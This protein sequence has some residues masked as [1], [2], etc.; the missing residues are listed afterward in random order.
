MA[1]S[2]DGYDDVFSPPSSTLTTATTTNPRTRKMSST[3]SNTNTDLVSHTSSAGDMRLYLQNLLDRKEKQLQQAGALGQRVLAQ[4]VELEERVRELQELDADK[5]LGE[6]DEIDADMRERYRQLA[7]SF[8]VWDAENVQLS[9][10]FGKVSCCCSGWRVQWRG[11]LV[12]PFNRGFV[13]VKY[14]GRKCLHPN[15]CAV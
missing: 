6:D 14:R 13:S 9:T 5:A 7:Q 12:A 10:A 11:V 8:T 3:H 15:S 2:S 4:Q 1:N